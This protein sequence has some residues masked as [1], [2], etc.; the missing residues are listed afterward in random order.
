M[1]AC[2]H[3][4]THTNTKAYRSMPGP[5]CCPK[6]RNTTFV[7]LRLVFVPWTLLTFILQ[8]KVLDVPPAEEGNSAQMRRGFTRAFPATDLSVYTHIILPFQ[9]GGSS[10]FFSFLFLCFFFFPVHITICSRP[11]L[12][13]LFKLLSLSKVNW[14]LWAE[15]GCGVGKNASGLDGLIEH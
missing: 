3:A 5:S 1:H 9:N 4:C 2:A 12:M 14:L 7:C 13:W 8:L 10:L 6:A 11:P 15:G